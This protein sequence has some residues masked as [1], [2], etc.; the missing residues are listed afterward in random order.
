MAKDDVQKILQT[1]IALSSLMGEA[2]ATQ[3]AGARD[4]LLKE[5]TEIDWEKCARARA[6]FFRD[7]WLN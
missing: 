2:G 6:H 3:M 5:K 7:G 1:K 4:E